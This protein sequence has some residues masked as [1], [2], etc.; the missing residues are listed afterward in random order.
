MFVNSESPLTWSQQYNRAVRLPQLPRHDGILIDPENPKECDDA[1]K[2]TK[3]ADESWLLEVAIAAPAV[4]FDHQQPLF[5]EV[6]AQAESEYDPY[7]SMLPSNLWRLFDLTRHGCP[8]LLVSQEIRRIQ[9]HKPSPIRLNLVTFH[10]TA[11]YTYE[12]ANEVLAA[13][14][15]STEARQLL[16]ASD[17]IHAWQGQEGNG[18]A[19]LYEGGVPDYYSAKELVRWLMVYANV[20]LTKFAMNNGVPILSRNYHPQVLAKPGNCTHRDGPCDQPLDGRGYYCPHARAHM[21]AHISSVYAH[22]TSPLRRFADIIDHIQLLAYLRKEPYPFDRNQ[23]CE[24][25]RIIN[26]QNTTNWT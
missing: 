14:R 23:L 20:S 17:A 7:K 1:F 25:G 21:D 2:A 24:M 5:A 16:M 9:P 13:R 19:R 12:Q 8:A 22:M 18:I 15:N 10:P 3:I 11:S 26:E 6:M 4:V